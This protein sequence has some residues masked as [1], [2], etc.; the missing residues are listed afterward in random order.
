V[1]LS[2]VKV[3]RSGLMNGLK[4]KLMG[5]GEI[6]R[7]WCSEPDLAPPGKLSGFG[8]LKFYPLQTGSPS[9]M[10]A[11]IATGSWPCPGLRRG[12]AHHTYEAAPAD[13]VQGWGATPESAGARLAVYMR[14]LWPSAGL[15]RVRGL[16]ARRGTRQVIVGSPDGG[17]S[18]GLSEEDFIFRVGCAAE[19]SRTQQRECI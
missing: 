6:I 12:T 13:E 4:L 8:N 19:T 17:G 10:S 18:R 9:S 16:L 7:L 5:E 14:Q 1:G 15:T 11:M 3:A 2:H